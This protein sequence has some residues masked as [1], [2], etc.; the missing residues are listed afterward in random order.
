S[1][2]LANAGVAGQEP[3]QRGPARRTH[4]TPAHLPRLG[5]QHIERDLSTVHI[6]RPYDGHQSLLTLQKL[7]RIYRALSW[8]GSHCMSSLVSRPPQCMFL[9]RVGST[10]RRSTTW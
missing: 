5:I 8:G 3:P 9:C 2:D 7:T 1:S 6:K 4:Q 10:G